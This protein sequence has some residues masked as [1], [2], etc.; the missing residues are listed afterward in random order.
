MEQKQCCL[1]TSVMT[2]PVWRLKLKLIINKPDGMHLTCWMK[3]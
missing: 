3:K 2:H 1:V